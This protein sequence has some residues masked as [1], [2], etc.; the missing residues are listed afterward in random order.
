MWDRGSL[1]PS[2]CGS[3]RNVQVLVTLTD[4]LLSHSGVSSE[5]FL[6]VLATGDKMKQTVTL[7]Q[8]RM[9][10]GLNNVQTCKHTTQQNI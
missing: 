7:S 2:M 5:V 1:V 10:L 8:L 4:L 9:T 3:V 6:E